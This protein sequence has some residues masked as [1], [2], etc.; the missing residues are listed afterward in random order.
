L[1][2]IVQQK[3][4]NSTAISSPIVCCLAAVVQFSRHLFSSSCSIQPLFVQPPL[5]RHCSAA[6]RSIQPLLYLFAN[7]SLF[8]IVQQQ[9]FC[10]AATVFVRHLFS[11]NNQIIFVVL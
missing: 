2:A 9:S 5:V 4:F 7:C 3:L 6:T 10:S 8:A 1:F 11:N